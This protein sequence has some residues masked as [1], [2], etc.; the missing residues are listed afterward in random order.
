MQKFKDNA[1][2]FIEANYAFVTEKN[3][4][5]AA[6]VTASDYVI[7]CPEAERYK[8]EIESL[9][10]GFIVTLV[11]KGEET[12]KDATGLVYGIKVVGGIIYAR[13]AF[14]NK[15]FRVDHFIKYLEDRFG[16][17]IALTDVTRKAQLIWDNDRFVTA[18]EYM[19]TI[20]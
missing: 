8:D 9:T 7:R 12:T 17:K 15:N 19:E 13:F 16:L 2:P 4:G 10:A 18:K 20:R 11:K 6:R 1:P 5:L 3:P 14:G